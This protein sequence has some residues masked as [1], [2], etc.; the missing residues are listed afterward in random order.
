MAQPE[1]HEVTIEVLQ[2]SAE[3]DLHAV[4]LLLELVGMRAR[5]IADLHRAVD[6]STDT[7]VALHGP[8]VIGFGRLITDGVYYGSLWDIAVLPDFQRRGVGRR[9][10]QA[11]IEK[12]RA[13]GLYMIGL[14]TSNYNDLFYENLGFKVISDVHAMT[15]TLT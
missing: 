14:F 8:D 11:L 2:D 9:I 4:S 3:V 13:R 15:T 12:A 1:A 7:A 10:V 6:A 5:S